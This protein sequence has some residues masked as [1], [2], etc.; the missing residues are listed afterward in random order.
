MTKYKKLE[1]FVEVELKRLL[2]PFSKGDDVSWVELALDYLQNYF[3][4]SYTIRI[5]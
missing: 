1:R 3:P 2:N 5:C 4:R